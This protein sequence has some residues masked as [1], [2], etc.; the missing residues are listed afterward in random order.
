MPAKESIQHVLD[1][2]RPPRVQITYDVEIGDAVEQKELPLVV[3]VLA[4]RLA[5]RR[6]SRA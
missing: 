3:G 1:R 2:V 4:D 6:S 5:S